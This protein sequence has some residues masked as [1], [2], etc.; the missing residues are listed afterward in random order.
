MSIFY[1]CNYI[2]WALCCVFAFFLFGDFIRTECKFAK[3][4]KKQEAIV[5]EPNEYN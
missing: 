3:E 4:N 5:D 1:I 2:A